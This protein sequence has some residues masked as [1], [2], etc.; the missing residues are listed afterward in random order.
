MVFST[1]EVHNMVKISF[2]QLFAQISRDNL[3]ASAMS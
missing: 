1:D 3:L 2:Q